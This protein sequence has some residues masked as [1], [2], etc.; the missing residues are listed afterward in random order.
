[1][2]HTNRLTRAQA[3]IDH[4]QRQ[5]AYLTRQNSH[6]RSQVERLNT[7]LTSLKEN[8]TTASRTNNSLSSQLSHHTTRE[9]QISD[10][11]VS[12]SDLQTRYETKVRSYGHIHLEKA[13]LLSALDKANKKLLSQTT[14]I[15]SLRES[16]QTL[17]TDLEQ[18]RDDLLNSDNADLARLATAEATA[19]AAEKEVS[20]LTSKFTSLASDL[21]FARQAY[22]SASTSA[23]D[24]AGQVS[25]LT[26]SLETAERKAAGEATRLAEANRDNAVREAKKQVR[27][28]KVALEERE[29]VCRRKE[30]EIETLKGRRGRGGVVTRGGSV[31]PG[32]LGPGG[33][34]KSPRGSRGGSPMPGVGLGMMVG[35]E[36]MRRGGSGLRGEVVG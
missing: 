18:A 8:L 14:E 4:L 1:M 20:T 30:E 29:K 10:L 27:Q 2:P 28:L 13:D 21:D 22:Q 9:S 17:Q 33:Q 32:A 34:G 35:G 25:A 6:L 16:K 36:G 7:S 23:A 12:L 31:Q 19:R 24:L 11:E 26:T 15:T 3:Q 5:N